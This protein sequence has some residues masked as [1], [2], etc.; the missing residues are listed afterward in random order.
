MVTLR[1]KIWPSFLFQL[2]SRSDCALMSVMSFLKTL[3][4]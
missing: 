3:E 1:L 2:G 4:S